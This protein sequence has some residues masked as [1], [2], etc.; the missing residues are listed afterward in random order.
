MREKS[1]MS[2][3]F[4]KKL[5]AKTLFMRKAGSYKCSEQ[6]RGQRDT[7]LNQNTFISN[8]YMWLIFLGHNSS[9]MKV[10]EHLE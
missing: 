4:F 2:L 9:G 10:K 3:V 7:R 1:H 5:N 8:Y 6:H